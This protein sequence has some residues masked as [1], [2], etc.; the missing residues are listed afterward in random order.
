MSDPADLARGWFRKGDS[1]LSTARL[2]AAGAGPYDTACFHAQQAA[3]KYLKGFLSLVRQPFPL[4]H[5][6]EEL[7]RRCSAVN[8]APDLAGCDL[9]QL[10]PYAVQLRYDSSFWPDQTTALEAIDL[11]EQVRTAVLAVAPPAAHP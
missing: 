5:N 8:P 3:E 11:A 2:V 6:L 1:D 7:E 4:T 9:T 10:T